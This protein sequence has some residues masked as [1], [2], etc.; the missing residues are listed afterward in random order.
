M[1]YKAIILSLLVSSCC[2][3]WGQTSNHPIK[4]SNDIDLIRLSPNAY[5]HVSRAAMGSFGLVSSNGLI[6]I[7]KGKA[8][9]FDTPVDEAQTKTLITWIEKNLHVS[10][11]GF[12]PNHWHGDCMGGLAYIK[13]RH[14]PSYANH[15]TIDLARKHHLPL[16]DKGFRD[17]LK[18][19]LNDKAIECYYP[20]AAHST[21]N[22]VVWIPSEKILFA[23][24]MAKEMKAT[25]KGNLADADLK[26]WPNTIKKVM[27]KFPSAR[28]V[29][30]GHGD[31]GGV[32][33]LQHT[34][35]VINK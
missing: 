17:S 5:I 16:P 19:K 27:A 23:G 2:A 35:D 29:I 4:V 11:V 3:L 12:V 30:P 18:L 6:F 8:F 24:C 31:A 14:I 15:M 22:I 13:A 9:L 32:E 33:L 1:K 7:D 28:I 34:L 21:D 20:G 25:T 26:A 10:F